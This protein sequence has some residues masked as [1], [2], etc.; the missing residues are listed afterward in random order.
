MAEVLVEFTATLMRNGRDYR[1]RVCGRIAEDGL[2]EGWI[3][4]L[5]GDGSVVRTSRESEQPDRGALVYW[6][7]GLTMTYL[8][9]ALDRALKKVVPPRGPVTVATAPAFD[10]P[11]PRIPAPP[12]LTLRPVLDPFDTYAQGEGVLRAQLRALSPD[13]LRVICEAYGIGS[14]ESVSELNRMGHSELSEQIMHG[15]RG[16]LGVV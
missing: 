7:E 4:F 12:R 15:V 10:G 3:E 9:G 1:P 11:A 8:D 16:R 2:W 13:Q 5:G 6:A 14:W